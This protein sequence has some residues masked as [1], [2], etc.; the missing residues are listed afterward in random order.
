MEKI[1]IADRI[2]TFDKYWHSRMVAEFNQQAV[3]LV[4]MNGEFDWHRNDEQDEL[5]LALRGMI[6]I[7]FEDESIVLNEGELFIVPRGRSH[8]LQSSQDAHLLSI[9]PRDF[10]HSDPGA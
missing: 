2:R 6:H 4:K 10:I 5:Y 3:R 9:A 1:N 8:R 7:E